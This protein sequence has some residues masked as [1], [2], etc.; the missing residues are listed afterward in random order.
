MNHIHIR[1]QTRIHIYTN[2]ANLICPLQRL[3][4]GG[5]S[6]DARPSDERP[7]QTGATSATAAA[8]SRPI[9]GARDEQRAARALGAA[10]SHRKLDSSLLAGRWRHG[11]RP[12]R[13][14]RRPA[15]LQPARPV[16]GARSLRLSGQLLGTHLR[17]R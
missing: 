14:P 16:H 12:V 3:L 17:P 9:R 7:C 13:G 5:R 6:V 2:S 10:R 4:A 8:A 1:R 15:G 11:R